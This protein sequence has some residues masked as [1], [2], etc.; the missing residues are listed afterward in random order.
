MALEADDEANANKEP[1]EDAGDKLEIDPE[2]VQMLKQIIK[3]TTGGQPSTVP[4]SGDKQISGPKRT[5]I[6]CVRSVTR[7]ISSTSRPIVPTKLIR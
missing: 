2:E 1:T 6:S 7:Q 5:S 4:K 3:P